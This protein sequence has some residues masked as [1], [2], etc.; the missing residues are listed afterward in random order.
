MTDRTFTIVVIDDHHENLDKQLDEVGEY[1]EDKG[2]ELVPL[3]SKKVEDLDGFLDG[4]IVDI[5]LADKNLGS[6]RTGKEVVERTR[7]KNVLADILYYSAAIEDEDIMELSLHLGVQVIKHRDFVQ[8]LKK[9]IDRNLLKWEDAVFL[10]G[11]VISRTIEME[12]KM[13]E[14]LAKYFGVKDDKLEY[15]DFML[16][17]PTINLEGKKATITNI[18]KKEAMPEL[19][20]TI[21]KKGV[22]EAQETRNILA[23]RI[24]DPSSRSFR[25]K[26]RIFDKAEM[27][28]ILGRIENTLK[29][30][31]SAIERL[32]LV[33]AG[34]N[35]S[36]GR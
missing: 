26:G 14:F 21:I 24:R 5:I 35:N 13:N 1:L 34:A 27:N 8:P 30:L 16:E 32:Q 28:K 20:I 4:S 25:A 10:R 33:P 3:K 23:H 9:M 19:D 6:G 12:S 31:D 7:A 2:F 11:I 36:F 22:T 17:G 18:M 29:N 15:F